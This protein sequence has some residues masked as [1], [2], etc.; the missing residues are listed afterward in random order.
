MKI[1]KSQEFENVVSSVGAH[2]LDSFPSPASFDATVAG[3]DKVGMSDWSR[4]NNL[5]E[6]TETE[7]SS[8]E[9][10][11]LACVRWL[12]A[13]GYIRVGQYYSVHDI[14]VDQVVLTKTGL[15]LFN[16]LPPCLKSGYYN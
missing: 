6:P 13:E 15:E 14:G 9:L 10:F 8:D 1:A 2:L 3:Y 4:R 5:G 12:E 7:P 16:T 11:F